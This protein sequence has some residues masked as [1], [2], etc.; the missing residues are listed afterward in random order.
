M[1]RTANSA[2][3]KKWLNRNRLDNDFCKEYVD[4]LCKQKFS[5]T[6]YSFATYNGDSTALYIT[7]NLHSYM[8]FVDEEYICLKLME[9]NTKESNRYHE[10]KIFYGD[11]CWIECLS[12]IKNRI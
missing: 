11:N 4:S 8:I 3:S 6:E 10:L 1:Q 5:S 9:E 7:S 12:Y 2:R